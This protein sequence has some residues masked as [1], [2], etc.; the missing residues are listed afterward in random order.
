MD[1]MLFFLET[2]KYGHL[3]TSPAREVEENDK[4]IRTTMT[5]TELFISTTSSAAN[6]DDDVVDVVV[7]FGARGRQ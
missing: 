6:D 5:P 2:Q 3:C 7:Q 1:A 4:A